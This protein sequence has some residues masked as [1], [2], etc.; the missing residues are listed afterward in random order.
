MALGLRTYFTPRIGFVQKY[1]FSEFNNNNNKKQQ[2]ILLKRTMWYNNLWYPNWT[3]ETHM[4]IKEKIGFL[5]KTVFD[6]GNE[7][8]DRILPKNRVSYALVETQPCR[9][10]PCEIQPIDL[11]TRVFFIRMYTGNAPGKN[12]LHTCHLYKTVGKVRSQWYLLNEWKERGNDRRFHVLC[13]QDP[14]GYSCAEEETNN[15]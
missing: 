11:L 8:T 7:N 5:F 13:H 6:D 1:R 15:Y 9:A 4:R 12:T 2:L 10:Q 14:L 3:N